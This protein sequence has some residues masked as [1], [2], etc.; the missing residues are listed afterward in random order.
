MYG[1]YE[2]EKLTKMAKALYREER[3]IKRLEKYLSGSK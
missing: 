1:I 3:E 2:S